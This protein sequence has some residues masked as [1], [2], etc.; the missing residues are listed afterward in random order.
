M[1]PPPPE[2]PAAA[3]VA[4]PAGESESESTFSGPVADPC[5]ARRAYL[6]RGFFLTGAAEAG[7]GASGEAEDEDACEEEALFLSTPGFDIFAGSGG[8]YGRFTLISEEE[9]EEE[10]G[11]FPPLS[12]SIL[13]LSFSPPSSPSEVALE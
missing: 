10:E 12:S 13:S 3:A 8:L 7:L 9:E 2:A 4:L 1:A 5:L 6:D 11:D